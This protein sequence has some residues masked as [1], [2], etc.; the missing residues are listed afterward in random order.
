VRAGRRFQRVGRRV[1]PGQRAARQDP[2]PQRDRR[3]P[4]GVVKPPP[5]ARSTCPSG[6]DQAAG[7]RF[8]ACAVDIGL[9]SDGGGSG[10]MPQCRGRHGTGVSACRRTRCPIGDRAGETM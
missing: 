3:G 2:S 1:R 10:Q 4:G 9:A 5:R 8:L 7:Q 6:A